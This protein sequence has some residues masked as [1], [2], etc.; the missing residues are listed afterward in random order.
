[1]VAQNTMYTHGGKKGIQSVKG[2]CLHSV[3]FEIHY[4]Q[5]PVCLTAGKT[6]SEMIIL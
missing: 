1:M 3:K 2:I 6:W 4:Q 5:R